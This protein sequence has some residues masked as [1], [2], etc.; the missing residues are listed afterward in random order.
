MEKQSC[1]Q[2]EISSGNN[3]TYFFGKGHQTKFGKTAYEIYESGSVSPVYEYLGIATSFLLGGFIDYPPM[4][5]TLDGETPSYK[6]N[7]YRPNQ[8]AFK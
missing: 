4:D 3:N 1:I 5:I 6:N 2:S 8:Q 7:K